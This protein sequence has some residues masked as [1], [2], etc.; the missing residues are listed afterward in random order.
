MTKLTA[1]R[2]KAPRQVTWQMLSLF[3]LAAVLF[4]AAWWIYA[5]VTS[6]DP[7]LRTAEL[8]LRHQSRDQAADAPTLRFLTDL[9]HRVDHLP[10]LDPGEALSTRMQFYPTDWW[11]NSYNPTT[12]HLS[13]LP[14]GWGIDGVECTDP[15]VVDYHHTTNGFRLTYNSEQVG[16]DEIS[17][18]C[19]IWTKLLSE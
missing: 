5:L 10:P 12:I 19:T 7:Q 9:S 13:E 4:A 18:S 2:T 8:G 17:I 1:D 15:A 16:D 3:V 11:A 6:S 14:A